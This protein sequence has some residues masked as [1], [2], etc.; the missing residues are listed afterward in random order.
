MTEPNPYEPPKSNEGTGGR[1]TIVTWA[2]MAMLLT[3]PMLVVVPYALINTFGMPGA[4]DI[5]ALI[6]QMIIYWAMCGL[7]GAGIG[8]LVVCARKWLARRA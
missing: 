3:S 2:I 5:V 8:W 7:A 1:K 4:F 6:V